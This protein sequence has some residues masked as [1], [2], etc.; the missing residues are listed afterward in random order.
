MIRG[1]GVECTVESFSYLEAQLSFLLAVIG[2]K[3]AQV[4][5]VWEWVLELYVCWQQQIDELFCIFSYSFQKYFGGTEGH[6]YRFP[7]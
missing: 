4:L 7:A 5:D 6:I 2:V 1:R 3:L